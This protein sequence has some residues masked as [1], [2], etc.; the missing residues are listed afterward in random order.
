MPAPAI[1]PLSAPVLPS[2]VPQAEEL[3]QPF[4]DERQRKH[5]LEMAELKKQMEERQTQYSLETPWLW[6]RI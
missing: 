1:A 4:D 2:T 5:A 6:K 3:K